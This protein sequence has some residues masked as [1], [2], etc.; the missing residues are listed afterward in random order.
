M[1]V[2]H[3][4]GRQR[5]TAPGLTQR[6][7]SV[8]E[9]VA[10]ATE[11]V[12][13]RGLARVL[14]IDR[15]A[16]ARILRQLSD[17]DVFERVDG[18]Y[19]AGPRLVAL[20]RVLASVDTLPDA[21]PVILHELVRRFNE[22]SYVC[23]RHGESAVFLH[24]VQ[25]DHPV[26]FVVEPG[27]PVPLHAGAAGR[28]ILAGLPPEE[29]AAIVGVGPLPRITDNT[30]TEVSLLLELAELDRARGYSISEEERIVGGCAVAA[31]FFDRRGVCQG[32]V[33]YTCPLARLER[34]RLD[35]IGAAVAGA[36]R[37][38]SARLGFRSPDR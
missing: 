34:E 13:P 14:G 10:Q 30:V 31:P 15:S 8:I 20:G 21:A 18:A 16:V 24:E 4:A 27:K 29:A 11:P 36:A 9:G 7:V 37:D 38:L 28:A 2:G 17:L 23:V 19:V 1:S 25:G 33:V 22:T 32:S 5:P 3:P 35:E 26:R 12:G 6:V